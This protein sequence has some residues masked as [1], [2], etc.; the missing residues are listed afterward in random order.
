MTKRQAVTT[1]APDP[2]EQ[3]AQHFD[4]LFSKLNQRQGFHQYLEGLLLPGENDAN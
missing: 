1:A 3:Y 2:L 4:D